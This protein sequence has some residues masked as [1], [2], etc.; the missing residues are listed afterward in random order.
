M[1]VVG[2]RGERLVELMGDPGRHLSDGGHARHVQ[3]APMQDGQGIGCRLGGRL[4]RRWRVSPTI[5]V[6]VRL[7]IPDLSF[8]NPRSQDLRL[9]VSFTEI[10]PTSPRP[11]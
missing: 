5:T 7:A 11:M 10:G 4:R 3:Q 1:C 9:Y 8:E 6:H 2:D